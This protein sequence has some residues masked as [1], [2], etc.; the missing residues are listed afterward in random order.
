MPK[1]FVF[2]SLPIVSFHHTHEFRALAVYVRAVTLGPKVSRTDMNPHRLPRFS[3]STSPSSADHGETP[4]PSYRASL[5]TKPS[6]DVISR[7]ER[8]LAQYNASQNLY[9]RWLFEILSV[10]TSAICM[11]KA[12][13]LCCKYQDVT[14]CRS[15][16][17]HT[18]CVK[19]PT[20]RA[21]AP[22][23]NYHHRSFQSR[24]GSAHFTHFGSY[25]TAE[26]VLVPR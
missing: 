11:G 22:W 25:W 15:D 14:P 10:T 4:P 8:K 20:T 12:S 7:I 18:R 3:T 13:N 5:R 24:I 9:K 16:Y 17:R 2:P 6:S 19:R 26:V 21:M 23:T 1:T